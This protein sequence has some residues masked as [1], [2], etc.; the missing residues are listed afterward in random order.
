MLQFIKIKNITL[1]LL[2]LNLYLNVLFITIFTTATT[3]EKAKYM[4]PLAEW[5]INKGKAGDKSTHR[6]LNRVFYDIAA[7]KKVTNELAPRF[8][9]SL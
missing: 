9:Y 8:R 6:H 4:R 2:I 3:L 1:L 7:I 5:V